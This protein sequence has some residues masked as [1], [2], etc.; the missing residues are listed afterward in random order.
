MM[1]IRIIRTY[2]AAIV[3]M[4][5]T[6]CLETQNKKLCKNKLTS[7]NH[8]NN[9][10]RARLNGTGTGTDS[11]SQGQ[12]WPRSLMRAAMETV[13]PTFSNNRV[14]RLQRLSQSIFPNMASSGN[15]LLSS[16]TSSRQV[17]DASMWAVLISMMCMMHYVSGRTKKTYQSGI[18]KWVVPLTELRILA[19]WWRSSVLRH[20]SQYSVSNKY[21]KITTTRFNSIFS[22]LTWKY[23]TMLNSSPGP[24]TRIKLRRM[25]RSIYLLSAET[26]NGENIAYL[27]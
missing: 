11:L 25:G 15:P 19:S 12:V 7:S 14:R 21:P 17:K 10:P 26:K 20:A 6:I 9:M 1:I 4:H 8:L 3:L 24:G 18:K 13:P 5:W 16:F 22:C 2:I 27:Y 23:V